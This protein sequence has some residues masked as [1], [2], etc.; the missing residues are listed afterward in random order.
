MF[1]NKIDSQR[2]F[3]LWSPV[4]AAL[5][6][7]FMAA[8]LSSPWMPAERLNAAEAIGRSA[9]IAGVSFLASLGSATLAF[10]FFQPRIALNP[11]WIS[12]ALAATSTWFAPFLVTAWDG[13]IW[14]LPIAMVIGALLARLL[15]Y[16][17]R[18]LAER[19]P[20]EDC[21]EWIHRLAHQMFSGLREVRPSPWKREA[22]TAALLIE[23]GIAAMLFGFLTPG[24][25]A[26]AGG[27]I[28]VGWS[29]RHTLEVSP[30]LLLR[31]GPSCASVAGALAVLVLIAMF[32]EPPLYPGMPR[33]DGGENGRQSPALA[34]KGLVGSFILQKEDLRKA[35]LV[36]P[37]PPRPSPI[38]SQGRRET[39][40]PFTGEYWFYPWPRWN[41]GKD[42]VLQR[43]SPLGWVFTNMEKSP[44]MMR[45]RQSFATPVPLECCRMLAITVTA[46]QAET[47]TVSIQAV[48]L[49]HDEKRRATQV[50]LGKIH[51]TPAALRNSP[52][53]SKPVTETLRF[54]VPDDTPIS[55]FDTI[56]VHFE[57]HAPRIH[58]S[59]KAEV[60]AFTFLP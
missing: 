22:L 15:G 32:G 54:A 58:R 42:A 19:D 18:S 46:M 5:V 9:A 51:L 3:V 43:G 35:V 29:T 11:R 13:A 30:A 34:D 16:Y 2:R 27:G 45:A 33:E 7:G 25:V 14:H 28:L 4:L 20:T 52:D 40:I 57:L 6:G 56:D 59:A 21:E 37:P 41:P 50:Q 55:E 26:V 39:R 36:A 49:R 10:R 31:R 1:E 38:R 17:Q 44:I 8:W 12:F 24:M 48:L 60:G 53:A 47:D 23:C